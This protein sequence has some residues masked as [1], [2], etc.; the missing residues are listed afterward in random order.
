[1]ID[2]VVESG[3]P[4]LGFLAHL[5]VLPTGQ[6][7]R[8]ECGW[9]SFAGFRAPYCKSSIRAEVVYALEG[10]LFLRESAQSEGVISA[11]TF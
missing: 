2:S 1:M 11:T 4:S 8:G 10:R 3:A 7:A 5:A 9:H 6:S